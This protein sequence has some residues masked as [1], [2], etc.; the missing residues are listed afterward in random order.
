ME[1]YIREEYLK[2]GRVV[3]GFGHAVLRTVDPRFLIQQEFAK[4]CIQG[5]PLAEYVILNVYYTFDAL[6]ISARLMS[7]VLVYWR[8][9]LALSRRCS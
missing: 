3:P 8:C 5:D 2:K 4:E 7:T 9:V 1:D 6:I